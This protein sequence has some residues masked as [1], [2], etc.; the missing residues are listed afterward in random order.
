LR[1]TERTPD[2]GK[3]YQHSHFNWRGCYTWQ[4]ISE[5]RKK[6]YRLSTFPH[7]C[8]G[9]KP[10]LRHRRFSD[11]KRC[12]NLTV[13]I[14]QNAPLK[15]WVNRTWHPQ[16]I[17]RNYLR[18]CTRKVRKVNSLAT[19]LIEDLTRREIY[20][21][22]MEAEKQ[23]LTTII[24]GGQ[25]S[26]WINNHQIIWPTGDILDAYL[27]GSQGKVDF[28]LISPTLSIPEMLEFKTGTQY[29]LSSLQLLDRYRV[30][31]LTSKMWR[32]GGWP[33]GLSRTEFLAYMHLE[34]GYCS[35][36]SSQA[37]AARY[38]PPDPRLASLRDRV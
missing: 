16:C 18:R 9:H 8:R 36:R 6:H 35:G 7:S 19:L 1:E 14:H 30:N 31:R 27:L 25:S 22:E 4:N 5:F 11:I 21:M 24:E 3:D 34:V 10:I 2:M 29:Q 15:P 32:R 23:G 20:S 13:C 33:P 28:R 38:W 12:R 17:G 37:N 26:D